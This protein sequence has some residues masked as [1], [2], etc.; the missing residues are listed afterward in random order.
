MSIVQ[1]ESN[2]TP[3][4]FIQ[5]A[6]S[7]GLSVEHLERLMALQER[8]QANQAKIAFLDAMNLFQTSVPVLEKKKQVKFNST[9]YKYATLGEIVETIK[10]TLKLSQLSY[11]WEFEDKESQIVCTCI[12]SHS[13]GH[14][15]SSKMSAG[16]DSSGNKND[17]Q[18]RGSTMTYLQ[19]YTLIAALGISTADEDTDGHR[20]IA[21]KVEA[22]PVQK[23]EEKPRSNDYYVIRDGLEW[24]EK[25]DTATIKDLEKMKLSMDAMKVDG[26][27]TEKEYSDLYEKSKK[28]YNK[29]FKTVSGNA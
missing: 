16:K 21:P 8:W 3:Q 15:E 13:A 6:I 7:Q 2:G 14:S 17:I 1:Q 19:R 4:Q 25:S 9:S 26:K 23:V 29:K 11:R 28:V 10:E 20:E 18:S 22:K 27:I 24:I 12:V 5:S